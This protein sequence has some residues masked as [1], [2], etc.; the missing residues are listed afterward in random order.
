MD[1]G[2]RASAW[3]VVAGGSHDD[4]A[5]ALQQVE[6]THV[7]ATDVGFPRLDLTLGFD[8]GV[9]LRVTPDPAEHE[10]AAW[11]LFTASGM[12]LQAG[13]GPRWRYASADEPS[14]SPSAE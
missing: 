12:Y 14:S 6:G 11:E 3:E 9:V 4:P 10:L 1:L 2:T 8:N 7:T 5:A 13:P